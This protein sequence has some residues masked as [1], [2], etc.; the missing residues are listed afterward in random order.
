MFLAMKTHFSSETYDYHKFKGKVKASFESFENRND[1]HVFKTLSGKSN[2]EGFLLGMFS[3]KDPKQIVSFTMMKEF[4]HQEYYEK[5]TKFN[6]APNYF[7]ETELSTLQAD[8]FRVKSSQHSG[9]LN[10]FYEK[11]LSPETLCIINDLT[12]AFSVWSRKMNDTL[13]WPD[14]RFRLEKYSK[15]VK[16]D[17]EKAKASLLT[18][19]K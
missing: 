13:L 14:T 18:M 1:K 9:V 15:F 17:K 2:P 12:N 3:R 6:S 4:E 7:F 8:D 19:T 10:A 16:Y 11:K 5:W